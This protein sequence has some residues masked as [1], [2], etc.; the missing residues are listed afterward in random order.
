MHKQTQNID[1]LKMSKIKTRLHAALVFRTYKPN[2]E[3]ARQNVIYLKT[4][5]KVKKYLLSFSMF[6]EV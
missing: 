6:K 1:L 4:M 3:K 5:L 2:N